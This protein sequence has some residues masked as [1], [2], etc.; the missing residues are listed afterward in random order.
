MM[1]T[2]RATPSAKRACAV[3]ALFV[4]VRG[5]RREEGK[6]GRS[7]GDEVGGCHVLPAAFA[8]A[9]GLEVPALGGLVVQRAGDVVRPAGVEALGGGVDSGGPVRQPARHVL[10]M[11]DSGAGWSGVVVVWWDGVWCW[12][13]VVWCGVVWC[14]LVL[15]LVWCGVG[16]GVY[17]CW[18][19]CVCGACAR[20]DV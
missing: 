1:P 2:I 4:E 8:P 11:V 14:G 9:A 20:T 5:V 18:C 7:H 6:A 15:V 13:G 16:V 19:W 3:R 17:W 10:L 12:W